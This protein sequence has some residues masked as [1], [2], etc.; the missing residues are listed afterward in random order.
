MPRTDRIM[1]NVVA[2]FAVFAV[3]IRR[4]LAAGSDSNQKN[5]GSVSLRRCLLL[6][7]ALNALN[8]T[9]NISIKP[10]QYIIVYPFQ[11]RGEIAQRNSHQCC[12]YHVLKN[13]CQHFATHPNI[14]QRLLEHGKGNS[15]ETGE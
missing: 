15:D 11:A 14:L 1:I 5:S 7:Q 10:N 8:L 2:W 3:Y 12:L 4:A 9:S 13:L 6:R